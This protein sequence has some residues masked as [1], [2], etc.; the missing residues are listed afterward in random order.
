MIIEVKEFNYY[1]ILIQRMDSKGWKF[2]F[3][4]NEYL[5]PNLQDAKKA[6]NDIRI[7]LAYYKM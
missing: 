5:F 3:G 6:I 7:M 2:S 1:G 4:E